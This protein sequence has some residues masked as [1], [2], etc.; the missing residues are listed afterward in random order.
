MDVGFFQAG[1]HMQAIAVGQAAGDKYLQCYSME[2]KEP[3]GDSAN[4]I[5]VNMVA[6]LKGRK[7]DARRTPVTLVSPRCPLATEA[8]GLL[9]RIEG[10]FLRE[11]LELCTERELIGPDLSSNPLDMSRV[12]KL[13]AHGNPPRSSGL[14]TQHI[15][16]ASSMQLTGRSTTSRWGGKQWFAA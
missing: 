2:Y 1:E 6:C 12:P 4:Q 11:W 3:Y 8:F 5:P 10:R 7:C 15:L 16:Q 13:I 14:G 9:L